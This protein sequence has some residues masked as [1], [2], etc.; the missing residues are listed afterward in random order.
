MIIE[1]KIL[2]PGV[3]FLLT[4]VTGLFI[5]KAGK[6]YN[7]TIFSIHKLISLAAILTSAIII[8]NLLKITEIKILIIILV[9]LVVLSVLALFITGALLSIG[10]A[11]Y[12]VVKTVHSVTSILL[13]VIIGILGFILIKRN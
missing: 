12:N 1:Q 4:I 13:L 9:I 10:K 7:N 6:P 5:S 2:V 3:L 8:F 11:S